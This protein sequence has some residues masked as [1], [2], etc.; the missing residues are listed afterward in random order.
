MPSFKYLIIGI[1]FHL[2]FS[3]LL[4]AQYRFYEN[5]DYGT[6]APNSKDIVSVDQANSGDFIATG[7]WKS[8]F[9][10]ADPF[11][12]RLNSQGDLLD[13]KSYHSGT[14]G[15]MISHHILKTSDGGALLSGYRYGSSG[16]AVLLKVG[17]NGSV[18]WDIGFTRGTNAEAMYAIEVGGSAPGYVVAGYSG[19]VGSER[20]MLA[21]VDL[22]GNVLWIKVYR[23]GPLKGFANCV[24][25]TQDGGLIATVQNSNTNLNF[26][27]IKT[28][29]DGTFS[30]AN[31]YDHYLNEYSMGVRQ[32]SNGNFVVAG[33]ASSAAQIMLMETN[34]AGTWQQTKTF[35]SLNSPEVSDLEISNAG[36]IAV[37]GKA[38]D[39]PLLLITDLSSNLLYGRSYA[40]STTPYLLSFI[41][42]SDGGYFMH[43][44]SLHNS[45]SDHLVKTDFQGSSGCADSPVNP[46]SSNLSPTVT[47]NSPITLSGFTTFDPDHTALTYTLN[48]I[49]DCC[50]NAVL[51]NSPGVGP[52]SQFH[53]RFGTIRNDGCFGMDLVNDNGAVLAGYT[54]GPKSNPDNDLMYAQ[55]DQDGNICWS[56]KI[57]LGDSDWALD[58]CTADGEEECGGY[59]LTGFS[60]DGDYDLFVM[61]TSPNGLPMW[62][63]TLPG[64]QREQ[65]FEVIG[66]D[67]GGVAMGGYTKSHGSGGADLVLASFQANGGLNWSYA[68]GTTEDDFC[69]AI[70]QK[71]DS[72][73]MTG[74]TFSN[75][76]TGASDI[77]LVKTNA[78]GVPV[79]DRIF[80]LNERDKGQDV[81]VDDDGNVYV[82]GETQRSETDW[83]VFLA[84]FNS[85]GT[86]LWFNVY[87]DPANSVRDV[88]YA[89]NFNPAQNRIYLS[90]ATDGFGA[91]S[92]DGLFFEVRDDGI[93]IRAHRFGGIGFDVF[94]GVEEASDG[95]IFLGGTTTTKDP[96]HQDFW[97]VKLD[98][99]YK[100][101][102]WEDYIEPEAVNFEPDVTS[103]LALRTL[104]LWVNLS[105][106]GESP[107]INKIDMCVPTKLENLET[108]LPPIDEAS[109]SLFQIAP[110]P[111]ND[112]VELSYHF[113]RETARNIQLMDLQGRILQQVEISAKSGVQ[114]LSLTNIP[115][116]IY[117]VRISG[118][119][120]GQIVKRLS[121][122]H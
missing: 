98:A 38:N 118:G 25:A 108:S 80:G 52:L 53:N 29:G 122:N 11:Y 24:Q 68:Y 47:S 6:G 87:Q 115:S 99:A 23:S 104:P 84:K 13:H 16:G 62:I 18:Q 86:L 9:M 102:C 93:L 14:G 120:E 2:G 112:R 39:S 94:F 54:A 42:A 100:S 116:G 35:N 114:S 37:H 63:N 121:V 65:G 89:M 33:Y 61:K 21:K 41:N 3:S 40:G 81:I 19:A 71:N 32:K 76:A 106:T 27:L 97:Q 70:D 110:N 73:Y 90:G 10:A 45:Y 83:D 66:L 34:S 56:H 82:C 91:V 57:D 95:S 113:K 64:N 12:I 36:H 22:S 67:N 1:L 46:S 69:F 20:P 103:D 75:A 88:A 4:P 17:L 43:Y 117:L 109:A 101:G 58:I 28:L 59:Y 51:C 77:Y 55:T 74:E 72:Y 7:W 85:S 31:T 44:S 60:D 48:P 15:S 92:S 8:F 5:L 96:N 78:S 119:P 107:L 49:K 79:W 30:W 111:A 50:T 105:Y 26:T